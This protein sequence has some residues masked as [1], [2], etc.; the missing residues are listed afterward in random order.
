MTGDVY[1]CMTASIVGSPDSGFGTSYYIDPRSFQSVAAA[2]HY[3][4]R[5]LDRSDDFNIGV[6][7]AG[8]LVA[9]TWMGDVLDDDPGLMELVERDCY[10]PHQ[11]SAP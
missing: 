9:I 5:Q 7:R 10:V 6:W 2:K 11:R 1:R 3:G 4:L 8:K